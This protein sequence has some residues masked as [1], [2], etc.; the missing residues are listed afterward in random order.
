VI[1]GYIAVLE[2][3]NGDYMHVEQIFLT[4]YWITIL[5]FLIDISYQKELKNR[6]ITAIFMLSMISFYVFYVALNMT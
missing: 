3:T 2:K 5:Y 4:M 6:V 1:I